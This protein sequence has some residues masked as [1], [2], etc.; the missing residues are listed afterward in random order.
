MNKIIDTILDYVEPDDEITLSS[1][2][3]S[4]CG[5]SSFDMVCL[6]EELSKEYDKAVQGEELKKCVTVKDL[7]DI[8][9]VTGEETV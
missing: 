9:G 1:K 6:I 2:L 5:L 7:C 3:R 8:F 4:D